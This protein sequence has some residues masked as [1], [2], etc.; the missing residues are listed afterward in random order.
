MNVTTSEF[1][2]A[3]GRW[4]AGAQQT[5]D[6][7]FTTHFPNTQVPVLK[8][9]PGGKRYLRVIRCETVDAESG[10]AFAFIEVATGNVYKPDGWKGPAKGARGNIYAFDGGLDHV[11]FASV[12]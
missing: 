11:G 1:Q 2:T 12:R 4:L 9:S 5:L 8:L 3:L 10:S 6:G 7:F